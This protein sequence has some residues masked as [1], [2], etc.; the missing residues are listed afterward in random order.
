MA[1]PSWRVP[2][3]NSAITIVSGLGAQA[4]SAKAAKTPIQLEAIVHQ[5]R[6]D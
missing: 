6:Q 5:A 1:W 4:T 3:T 2:I